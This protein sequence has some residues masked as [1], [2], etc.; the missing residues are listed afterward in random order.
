MRHGTNAADMS[1]AIA[2]HTQE[3]A[4]RLWVTRLA[5][6]LTP[7]RLCENTGISPQSWHNAQKGKARIGVDQAIKLCSEFGL[8][9]DWIYR[10]VRHGLPEGILEEVAR[11]D[12]M[13]LADLKKQEP[14]RTK[15]RRKSAPNKLK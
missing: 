10:G 9:L 8:T 15:R 1:A 5:L 2:T 13:T 12:R 6:K 4:R 14:P 11:L 7:A 3:V